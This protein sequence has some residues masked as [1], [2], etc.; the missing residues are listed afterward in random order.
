MNVQPLRPAQPVNPSSSADAGL[1]A[2]DY[3]ASLSS[4]N[5]PHSPIPSTAFVSSQVDDG[6]A[7]SAPPHDP[8]YL[9]ILPKPVDFSAL[10]IGQSSGLSPQPTRVESLSPNSFWAPD[11]SSVHPATD[12]TRE[13]SVASN[14]SSSNSKGCMV[15]FFKNH[16]FFPIHLH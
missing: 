16:I 12:S 7:V 8:S 1:W 9:S 13:P 11:A 4:D 2:S 15:S 6:S 5:R 3:D 14:D 10:S